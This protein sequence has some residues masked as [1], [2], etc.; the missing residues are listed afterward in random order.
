M[1]PSRRTPPGSTQRDHLN[2]GYFTFRDLPHAYPNSSA[3]VRAVTIPVPLA[4]LLPGSNRLE[5]RATKGVFVVNAELEIEL[6]Q[7]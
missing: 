1:A 5:L 4:D 2:L 3:G 7:P 6:E